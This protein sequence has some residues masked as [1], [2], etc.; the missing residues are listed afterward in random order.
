[1]TTR[2]AK[3]K[4][5]VIKVLAQ[6]EKAFRTN[7]ARALYWERFQKFD[8]K[9]LSALKADITKDVPST[10]QRGK[11]ANKPEP[12]QGWINWFTSQGLISIEK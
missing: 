10:P 3:S 6:P 4:G 11:L 5:P 9:P 7:S 1:M 12:I 2:T 8:G